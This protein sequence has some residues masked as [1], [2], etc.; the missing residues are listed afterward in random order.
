MPLVNAPTVITAHNNADFDALAAMVAA[1]KLYPD[2]VL[3]FP[4]SQEKTLRNFFIQSATYLFNFQ[5]AKDIDP[6]SVK[7]LVVVDT[8]QRARLSHLSQVFDNPGLEIHAYD[9]HPDS[10]DD[11]EHKQGVVKPW[12][13]A[14]AILVHEI[15][16]RGLDVTE[17]EATILGCGIFEDTGSFT[18]ASTTEHD[19][20]AAAWLKT[21]NMDV[22]VIADLLSRELSA[23][24]VALLNTLIESATAHEINGVQVVIAEASTD[25]YVGDFALLAHK[26]LDMENI[27]VLFAL[28]RMLD[29]IHV[30]A[31]SRTP[32]VDVGQ[33]CTSLGGGGHGFAAS[34]T[35]KDR[36]L[37]Q[38]KDEL[39]ALLYSHINPQL[40]VK[41]IMS[42]PAVTVWDTDTIDHAV[43][44]MTRYSLTAL[45]V[46]TE[47]DGSCAGILEHEIADKAVA[48]GLGHIPVAEYMQRECVI[49]HPGSDLYPVMEIIVGQGQHLA[50]V[51]E[52]G[53]VVGVITRTDLINTLIEEPARIPETL[54]PE[55]KRERN[56]RTLVRERMPGPVFAL[57]QEAGRLA[58]DM[59]CSVYA[60]GGFV[61]DI[62]L[63]RPNL[64]I[65]L[66]VEGDG[67]NFA[68]KLAK[69]LKGRIR[70][71]H[72]F[73]TAV[74]IHGDDERID[75][76]TARLEYYEYPAAL[77]TVELSSIKMDLFRRDFTVNAL[78]VQLNP[79]QFGRLVDFFGSQRD[80]KDRV[81]R[82]LHSL[83][84]VEDPTRILR[85]VRFEQRFQF[86]IGGQ[87]LRL[88]KNALQLDL[89]ERLSGSRLFHELKLI[90]EETHPLACL[91]RL[92]QLDVLK[93][94]H[95]DLMFNPA[96][97][98]LLE[99][100]ERILGWHRLLYLEPEP[101]AW[102]VYLL[103]FCEGWKAKDARHL[104][105][106]FN[107][108]PRETK[109]FLQL[110]HMIS[111]ASDKLF[112]W[113]GSQGSL[114]DLSEILENV[115]VEGVLYLM[116]RSRSESIRRHISLYLTKLRDMDLEIGGND[117]LSLGFTSGPAMGHVLRHIRAMK[118]D[119]H[120][121]DR[122][123]Q[124]A[125][126]EELLRQGRY[127]NE[128][129][130]K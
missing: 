103:C 20:T 29:R 74:V 79:G 108:S 18:F 66:V 91:R 100:A 11:L 10:D 65:D 126:A 39:F 77:P 3:V 32:D 113:S 95:P 59:G 107:L 58:E 92:Q 60:V 50:P 109:D 46:V 67:I 22:N 111:E 82:V 9:H 81:I 128:S 115:A 45:P 53:H 40:L 49:I 101:K 12:G 125:K 41:D 130:K 127:S 13:S 23:E 129:T 38:V 83:S 33:I 24:Q 80:I 87:T 96:K 31:R 73:R 1:G 47:L 70:A 55:R 117:L 42:S 93:A 28:G 102:V 54:I 121:G 116:A 63:M 16:K 37:S 75:V 76:A 72:K 90:M 64:D 17:D 68:R 34:A 84:F 8:R 98:A 124:M 51:I 69:H 61:R 105:Q 97:E 7:T 119:G 71:H 56:I 104:M 44:I 36:T 110:R 5:N 89:I 85:A 43:E 106:R 62:M 14:T 86:R 19:F 123:Q 114:S 35:V 4:G 120:V 21:R 27:R 2:A 25:H 15:I 30:V 112:I 6:A 99:E 26:L 88:I 78:A 118:Q 52:D 122:A 48:H 94:V 57:L